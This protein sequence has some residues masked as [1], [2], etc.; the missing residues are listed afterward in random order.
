MYIMYIYQMHAVYIYYLLFPFPFFHTT[1]PPSYLLPA[2]LKQMG[3]P[4]CDV[5]LL[6][7]SFS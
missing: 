2:D 5:I 4:L 3:P 1:L 7:G 6:L